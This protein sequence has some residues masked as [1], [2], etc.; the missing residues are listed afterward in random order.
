MTRQTRTMKG[1]LSFLSIVATL[2][3]A[4]AGVRDPVWVRVAAADS[5]RATLRTAT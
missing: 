3:I 5:R 2:G 4:N 1:A